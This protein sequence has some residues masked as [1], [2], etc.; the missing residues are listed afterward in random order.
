MTEAMAENQN[1]KRVM[2]VDDES[3]ALTLIRIML[4][5]NGFTVQG[6]KDALAALNLLETSTPDLFVLDVMMPGMDGIELCRR[7]RARPQTAHT[8]III[9]SARGDRESVAEGLAVGADDY[10]VKPI[11]HHDL[12]SKAR[13]LLG[14]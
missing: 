8:P 13:D 5:R 12:A 10:L 14:L 2:V 6:A 7:I 11:L 4:E 3:G 9:L 1:T